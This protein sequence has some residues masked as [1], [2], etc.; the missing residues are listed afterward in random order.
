[1]SS[2]RSAWRVCGGRSRWGSRSPPPTGSARRA[3][4]RRSRP[5]ATNS[6]MTNIRCG[7]SS[8]RRSGRGDPDPLCG[9]SSPEQKAWTAK[10]FDDVSG[11]VLTPLA[12]DPAHP[13]PDWCRSRSISPCRS[14][15]REAQAGVALRDRADSA[16]AAAASCASR[17]RGIPRLHPQKELVRANLERLFPGIQVVGSYPFRVTRNADIEVTEDEAGDLLQTIENKL[18]RRARR[19]GAA[20]SVLEDASRGR[21][22][23]PQQLVFG[24]R[25]PSPT[26]R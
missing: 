24:R 18:R 25:P 22:A 5:N 11:A 12:I 8:G 1:M 2:S 14:A 23:P 19:A 3:S 7:G 6:S 20:G 16:R 21:R 15:A 13:F 17:R 9:G 4:S 26:A 10:Y